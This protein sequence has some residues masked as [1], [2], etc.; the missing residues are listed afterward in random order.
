MNRFIYFQVNTPIS[1]IIIYF[2]TIAK[3]P[4]PNFLTAL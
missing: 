3:F 2:M 1:K 4:L